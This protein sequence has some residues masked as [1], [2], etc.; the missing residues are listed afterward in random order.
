LSDYQDAAALFQQAGDAHGHAIANLYIAMMH[1]R[2]RKTEHAKDQLQR[3]VTALHGLDE[4]AE[5]F[6]LRNLAQAEIASGDHEIAQVH[7]ERAL[8]LARSAKSRRREAQ[9][10]FQHGMLHL[11]RDQ[12]D[13]A[14]GVFLEVLA[15][16][17]GL[18][19]RVGEIQAL[20]GLALFHKAQ[21][22]TALARSTLSRALQLAQQPTRTLMENIV[23]QEIER[24]SDRTIEH[25]S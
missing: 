8:T 19:D 6:A 7:L 10:L 3:T 12:T 16:V 4:G 22:E 2:S 1:R 24:L 15:L 9:V 13:R 23:R 11:T 5:A 18:G 21:G 20:R 17:R 14:E 25:R